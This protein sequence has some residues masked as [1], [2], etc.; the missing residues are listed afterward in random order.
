M[1]NL[2]KLLDKLVA[3]ND[4]KRKLQEK[5]EI[6]EQRDELNKTLLASTILNRALNEPKYP[7]HVR[8]NSESAEVYAEQETKNTSRRR[9][10]YI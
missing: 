4:E 10:R 2:C 7:F 9:R 6:L 8:Q 1:E 5:V 3:V